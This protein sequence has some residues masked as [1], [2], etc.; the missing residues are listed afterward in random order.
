MTAWEAG[1]DPDPRKPTGELLADLV[2]EV[3][4]LAHA[5]AR[6]ALTEAR[7]KVRRAGVGVTALGAAAVLGLAALG[8]FIAAATLGLTLVLPAWLAALLVGVAVLLAAGLCALVARIAIRMALPIIPQETV[9][10][11]RQDAQ[12]IIKGARR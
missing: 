9:H 12:V 10:S 7:R 11:V 5:E 4:R 8:V 1:R 3:R 6:L 2:D